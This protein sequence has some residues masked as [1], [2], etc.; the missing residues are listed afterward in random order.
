MKNIKVNVEKIVDNAKNDNEFY[1]IVEELANRF[2]TNQCI[3]ILIPK[4]K[5]EGIHRIRK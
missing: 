3:G 1:R 2:N 5:H 4:D